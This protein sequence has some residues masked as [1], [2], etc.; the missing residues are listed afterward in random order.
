[1][2]EK[3]GW[4]GRPYYLKNNK[5]VYDSEVYAIFRA[6]KTIDSRESGRQYA[7]FSDSAWAG[8]APA[9]IAWTRDSASP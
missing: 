1:M 4:K 3:T 9:Q 6:L 5:D 7:I 2:C 8:T